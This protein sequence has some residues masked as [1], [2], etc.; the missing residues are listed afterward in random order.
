[1]FLDTVDEKTQLLRITF[2][3]Y[4]V[5]LRV[6]ARGLYLFILFVSFLKNNVHGQKRKDE[7]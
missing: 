6:H 4:Q 1:M 7:K 5:T 2:I 3:T